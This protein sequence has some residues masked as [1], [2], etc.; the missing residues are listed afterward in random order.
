[1]PNLGEEYKKIRAESVGH[2]FLLKTNLLI[3][4]TKLSSLAIKKYVPLIILT[5]KSYGQLIAPSMNATKELF[6]I[7]E[8]HQ[9]W[10]DRFIQPYEPKPTICLDVLEFDIFNPKF[11]TEI[12]KLLIEEEENYELSKIRFEEE[13]LAI[14]NFYIFPLIC[15]SDK[16][17]SHG[18]FSIKTINSEPQFLPELTEAET[19]MVVILPLS[20]IENLQLTFQ[21]YNSKN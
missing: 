4:L 13:W 12:N 21:R 20:N 9:L 3:K 8:N 16:K 5:D 1:M 2:I 10:H 18:T 7:F 19:E 6:R 15:H 11:I 14:L 17:F